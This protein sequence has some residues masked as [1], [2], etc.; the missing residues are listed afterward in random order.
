M[1]HLV[2]VVY[3]KMSLAALVVYHRMSLVLSMTSLV[4]RMMDLMDQQLGHRMTNLEL[5]FCFH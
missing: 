4:R 5:N 2:L 3:H 1:N